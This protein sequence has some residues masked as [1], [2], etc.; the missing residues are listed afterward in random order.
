MGDRTDE[1]VDPRVNLQ[2]KLTEEE[3]DVFRD[4]CEFEMRSYRDEFVWLMRRRADEVQ[5]ERAR[6]AGDPA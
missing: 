6:E 2:I 1:R 3:R 4:L 5:K